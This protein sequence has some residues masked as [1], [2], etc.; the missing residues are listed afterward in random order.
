MFLPG[1]VESLNIRSRHPPS[2]KVLPA[3]VLS[4]CLVIYLVVDFSC[5]TVRVKT[6]REMRSYQCQR[7]TRL[8]IGIISIYNFPHC[9][10]SVQTQICRKWLWRS[11][12]A[13]CRHDGRT[14][15]WDCDSDSQH[16]TPRY[17][18][19]FLQRRNSNQFWGFEYF[20][21]QSQLAWISLISI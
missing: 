10:H 5:L 3:P 20:S 11:L 18:A 21:N 12:A 7:V 6:S 8:V 4:Y 1:S 2:V 16:K 9:V 15:I 14:Q 17:V 13:F 19:L